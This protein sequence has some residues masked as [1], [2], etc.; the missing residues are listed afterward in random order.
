MGSL[1]A[2]TGARIVVID[3]KQPKRVYA[4]S[5]V[6]LYRS[7]DAG[8]TWQ[9]AMGGLPEGGVRTLALD[10]RQPPRLYA[11]TSAGALYGSEDGAS[12]WQALAGADASARR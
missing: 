2:K 1:P 4:M 12:S 11:T 7:D 8:E 9:S 3:P 10:P 5:D 6:S